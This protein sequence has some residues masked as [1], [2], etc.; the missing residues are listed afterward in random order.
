[1]RS[2][3]DLCEAGIDCRDCKH[4]DKGTVYSGTCG[5]AVFYECD[6][7][8]GE[9]RFIDECD[10]FDPIRPELVVE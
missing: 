8:D 6:Q 7:K 10:N 5:S 4:C 3:P 9:V 1:M 2:N